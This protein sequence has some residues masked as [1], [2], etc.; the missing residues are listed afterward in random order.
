[1]SADKRA[2]HDFSN[3]GFRLSP[4]SCSFGWLQKREPDGGHATRKR[5]ASSRNGAHHLMPSNTFSDVTQTVNPKPEP[6]VQRLL[7]VTP[8]GLPG[9]PH[10]A[11]ASFGNR[12]VRPFLATPESH[13]G[14][15]SVEVSRHAQP[16]I[17]LISSFPPLSSGR[18][19]SSATPRRTKPRHGVTHPPSR[20]TPLLLARIRA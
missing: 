8:S 14:S 19:K 1:M 20:V 7:T 18:S 12:Y 5:P 10:G 15:P 9:V 17:F 4:E 16:Y 3:T 2:T 13:I 6:D 11:S